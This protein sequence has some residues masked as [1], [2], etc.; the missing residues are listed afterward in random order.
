MTATILQ[1]NRAPYILATIGLLLFV[2]TFLHEN[3]SVSYAWRGTIDSVGKDGSYTPPASSTA[4][5][6]K[7]NR[8]SFYEV[9]LSYGTDKVTTHKYHHM[10]EKYLASLRDRPLKM[11]EIGLGCDMHYGP[12]KS[13]YTWLEYF[14][15][16]D[17][18]Y[19]EYDAACVAKWANSTT[20]ATIFSGDQADVA[21]LNRFMKEAGM[22]FDII[23]DDGGHRMTQQITSLNHLWKAVKPGGLYFCEDLQTS[24]WGRYGGD[25]RGGRG[26]GGPKTKTMMGVIKEMLDDLNIKAIANK[27]PNDLSE[28]PTE[29]ERTH[30]VS[31]DMLFIDCMEEICAFGKKDV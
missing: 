22:D 31:A 14:P 3:D 6:R 26:S 7:D 24:Y 17:L 27:A 23:L 4:S 21:F 1:A 18:Y 11:L 13:F 9:A 15:R 19:I 25:P 20:G 16:V 10:Y 5:A 28:E 30:K 8:P 12:G 29:L 2:A